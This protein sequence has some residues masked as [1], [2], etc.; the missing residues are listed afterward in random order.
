MGARPAFFM[1][2]WD[3]TLAVAT[4]IDFNGSAAYFLYENMGHY[5]SSC[6]TWAL[7]AETKKTIVKETMTID[8]CG[9]SGKVQKGTKKGCHE[10]Y[11]LES[12][13]KEKYNC[14]YAGRF[15][16]IL[17]FVLFSE[18]AF[19]FY[20]RGETM[21]GNSLAFFLLLFMNVCFLRKGW[22]MIDDFLFFL[23]IFI[24]A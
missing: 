15:I 18:K 17:D 4:W 13:G 21:G 23:Q 6:Y 1:K 5:S 16:P 14:V 24:G 11:Y 22:I 10:T 8:H 3:I 12:E 2:T 19:Y 20:E 9:I 7:S